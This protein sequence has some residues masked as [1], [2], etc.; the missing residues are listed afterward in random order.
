[1]SDSMTLFKFTCKDSNVMIE[2]LLTL[3]SAVVLL[4][5]SPGPA[6][7]ALAAVGAS[8]GVRKGLPFLVGLVL[9]L[10]AAM[11]GTVVGLATL[12]SIYPTAK[13]VLQIIGG[14]YI[15]YVAFKVATAPIIEDPTIQAKAPSFN[16]GFILNIVNPKAYAALFAIFSQFTLPMQSN[17]LS[18]FSTAV[19]CIAAVILV[20][21]VWLA[22]GGVIKP[23]FK[24]PV[25]AR[26]LRITFAILM[27]ITVAW[28]LLKLI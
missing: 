3:I 13:I 2:A 14:L 8:F 20:D 21:G 27:I 11:I 10:V 9:G 24:K 5:G 28:T 25:Q 15:V 16:D 18:L 12:L 1:L 26:I 23:I 17:E 6:P 22:L 7:L 19:V 4:L